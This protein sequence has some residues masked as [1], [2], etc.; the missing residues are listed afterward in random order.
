MS[1]LKKYGTKHRKF[2]EGGVA[3]APVD[4]AAAGP[5]QGGGGQEEQIMA[6]A[7]ATVSGD[8]EAAAQLGQML[9]PMIMQEVQAAQGGGGE[10]APAPAE[11]EP[12]FRKGG[13]FV[14]NRV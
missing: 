4:P 1:Y 3:P 12:V 7:Q 6:L 11:G 5:E 14:G 13:I 8:M 9:A 10:A 2:Q